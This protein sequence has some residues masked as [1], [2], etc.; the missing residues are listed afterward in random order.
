M[1]DFKRINIFGSEVTKITKEEAPGAVS[2]LV[3]SKKSGYICFPDAFV[4]VSASRNKKLQNILNNSLITFPDGQPLVIYA[5]KKG[6]KKITTVSGYWLIKELLKKDMTHFFYGS[7]QENLDKVKSNIEKEFPKSNIIGYKSAPFV[8][9][10][11]I[12]D[13]EQ[14][15]KDVE[16][17]NLLKPNIVWIGF[18]SPKQDYLMY[19]FSKYLDNSIMIGV[20]GVFDYISGRLKIS[21]EWIKKLSLRWAYRIIQNPK[22]YFKRNMYSIYHFIKL[23]IKT[24]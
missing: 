10:E 24:K 3:N 15:R 18:N 17:I 12:E 21:P 1:R 5:K 6:V 7:D 22:R 16:S 14:I 20:G 8:Q 19:N 9:L 4:I 23:F 11:E 13:N 2:N